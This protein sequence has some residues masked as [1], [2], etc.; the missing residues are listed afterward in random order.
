MAASRTVNIII[1]QGEDFTYKTQ[2]YANTSI[3]ENLGIPDGGVDHANSQMRKSYYHT[4]AAATFNVWINHTDNNI[5]LHLDAANT[6]TIAPGKY[7]YDVE[8]YDADGDL[9]GGPGGGGW[10]NSRRFRA[11]EGIITVTPE[12]SK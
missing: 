5:V 7:V 9:L 6:A 2:I 12:V 4:N 1:N 11:L 10:T 3:T 8:Y